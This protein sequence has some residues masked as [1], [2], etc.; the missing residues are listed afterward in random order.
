M[1]YWCLCSFSNIGWIR[2]G[3]CESWGCRKADLIIDNY[4]I[5]RKGRYGITKTQYKRRVKNGEDPR[6]IL[7][8]LVAEYKGL[9]DWTRAEKISNYFELS[10]DAT[11][12]ATIDYDEYDEFCCAV[13]SAN[14]GTGNFIASL[15]GGGIIPNNPFTEK[16]FFEYDPVTEGDN[17]GISLHYIKESEGT[18]LESITSVRNSFNTNVQDVDFD[19]APIV[20]PSPLSKDLEAVTQEFRLYSNDNEIVNWLVGAYYYQEDMNK[21][22]DFLKER[23]IENLPDWLSN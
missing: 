19:G 16:V 5:I 15:M 7:E 22:R 8:T 4:D 23:Q 21:T 9:E 6:P 18:T 11:L 1:K 12:R 20:N 3:P 13:G 2:R 17:S 10:N 14:Y